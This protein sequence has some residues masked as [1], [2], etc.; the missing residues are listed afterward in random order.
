MDELLNEYEAKGS[1]EQQRIIRELEDF[2]LRCRALAKPDKSEP[3]LPCPRRA[4]RSR[5]RWQF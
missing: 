1:S 2:I 4:G 3:M 5:L